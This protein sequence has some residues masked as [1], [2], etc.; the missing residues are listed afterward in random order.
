MDYANP[1]T[2]SF[3]FLAP[4]IPEQVF[5]M[6][7]L[8]F[9]IITAALITGSFADRM[10]YGS[11]IVFIAAWHVCVYC[12]IAHANFHQNGKFNLYH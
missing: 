12:P 10:K 7:Q 11:M 1:G 5:C 6:F 3:H 2:G 9:A 8:M 4:T